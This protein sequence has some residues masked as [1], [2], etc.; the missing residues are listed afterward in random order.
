MHPTLRWLVLSLSFFSLCPGTSANEIGLDASGPSRFGAKFSEDNGQRI[1]TFNGEH[2]ILNFVSFKSEGETEVSVLVKG[3][4]N[5]KLSFTGRLGSRELK[6]SATGTGKAEW[7]SLGKVKVAANLPTQLSLE[8]PDHNGGVVVSRFKFDIEATAVPVAHFKTAYAANPEVN[9]T[10][11]G[12]VGAAT[13]K[14][15]GLLLVPVVVEKAGSISFTARYNL[16]ANAKADLNLVATADYEAGKP[17]GTPVTLALTGTGKLNFSLPF[18]L[19]FPTAGTYLIVIN[20]PKASD[21][22]LTLNGLFLQQATNANLWSLPN[23]NAQSVHFGY[24]L[25]KGETAVFAYAEATSQPGPITTYNCVLGFGQG[26]FGFQRKNAGP[27]PAD[28]CFIY[29]LW[30]NGYVKNNVKSE[31]PEDLKNTVTRLIA[32]GEGVSA[33]AFDHEGSGGHSHWDYAWKDNQTYAFLLGVK[34][35]GDG[36]IF[37]TWVRLAETNQWKFLTSFR[38]PKTTAKLDGLY[39]FVEDW[40]GS[41]GFQKR[42]C[43]YSNL[44]IYNSQNKWVQLREAKSSATSELGRKD[45][46]HYVEGNGV[47][48]STGGYGPAKGSRGVILKIP[49][50]STPPTVNLATLPTN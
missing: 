36:A 46:D 50:S 8:A 39:S 41:A 32:K 2:G 12:G 3:A 18:S 33:S 15:A 9:V 34:P 25:P 30:D 31:N 5:A 45:Y 24:P 43:L 26:Y 6:G 48:L 1:A 16:A 42:A 44:W 47:V 4:A 29:S 27:N 20:H 17:T 40:S 19:N 14:G 38:R 13:F 35:D 23:G 28:R 37:S 11:R 10:D 49:E 21:A 22:P 7:V